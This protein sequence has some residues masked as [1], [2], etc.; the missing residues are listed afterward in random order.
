MEFKNINE[1]ECKELTEINNYKN[2]YYIT[3]KFYICNNGAIIYTDKNNNNINIFTS[4]ITYRKTKN[5]KVAQINF[6]V[7][8][9]YNEKTKKGSYLR[10]LIAIHDLI[11]KYYPDSIYNRDNNYYYKMHNSVEN[12][13]EQKEKK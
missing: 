1:I 2:V 5:S 13:N 6:R 3:R 4:D 11:K 8:Y 10:K 9:N 12:E 7:K